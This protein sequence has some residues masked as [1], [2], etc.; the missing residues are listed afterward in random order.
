MKSADNSIN[1]RRF[2]LNDLTLFQ[3]GAFIWLIVTLLGYFVYRTGGG[4]FLPGWLFF[5]FDAPDGR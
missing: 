3:L 1:K 2:N 5:A 4:R